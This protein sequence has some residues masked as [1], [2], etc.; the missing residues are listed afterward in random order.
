MS[1]P[2]RPEPPAP[3]ARPRGV[4]VRRAT[5]DDV[6]ALVA[7]MRDFH[8]E[9]GLTLDQAWAAESLA[10]LLSDPA[11]GCAWLARSGRGLVGH[12]VL[13]VRF[14]ME[15]GGLGGHI[16]DLY[17]RPEFRRRGVARALLEALSAECRARGCTSIHVEAGDENEPALALYAGFGLVAA[18]DGRRLL[19]GAVPAAGMSRGTGE[20]AAASEGASPGAND[21]PSKSADACAVTLREIT[22]DT[23]RDVIRLSVAEGQKGFVAP[24]AVSLAQ[25]LFAP[26]A[27]YRAIYY[28]EE[29]AGFVMLAD[30]SLMRPPPQKP[31]IGVWRFMIDARFQGR[32]IGRTALLQVIDHVRG[33]G[34]F[35]A[36]ALSYVPG[37]GCPEPFYRSLGF[38]H[39]GK[40]DDG[41]VVLEL[42]LDRDAA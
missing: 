6:G 33:K 17:V 31:A 39:T 26:Q 23:V 37:P 40:T 10:A 14:T 41:E 16:D 22:A 38:R 42:P 32:G 19:S 12:A 21:A 3:P 15:H 35:G 2:E 28:G 24:N 36:L 7:L 5:A 11:L 34:Q 27:W 13:S 20:P 9:S 25:A 18:T 1:D 30:E 8:A 4:T 29:P